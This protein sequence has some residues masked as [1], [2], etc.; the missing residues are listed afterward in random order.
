M[1]KVCFFLSLLPFD[2]KEGGG[3]GGGGGRGKSLMISIV[4][5][6]YI[7]ENG[8]NTKQMTKKQQV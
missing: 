5:T 1:V 2:R 6:I 7:L 4:D 8:K 3:G